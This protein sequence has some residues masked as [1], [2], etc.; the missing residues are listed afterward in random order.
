MPKEIW[1]PVI[2]YEGRYEVSNLGAV[3][4]TV[5][6]NGTSVRLL[7]PCVK[8]DGHLHLV[9]YK[10]QK[11]KTWM[12]HAL[13]MEAFVGPRPK[14]LETRHL[15]GNAQNNQLT[16]LKY[17][18]HKENMRDCSKHSGFPDRKGVNN[19]K[20]K[21]TPRQVLLIRHIYSTQ[22]ISQLQ[23]GKRFGMSEYAIWAIVNR[24]TWPNI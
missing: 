6:W 9:L 4:S 15:D 3:R 5:Q 22:K 19:V 7:K 18:T 17:G 14:G 2:G 20:A 23:L 21:L 12:I 24:K 10:N 11:P 13:V 1:K 8:K 16:N